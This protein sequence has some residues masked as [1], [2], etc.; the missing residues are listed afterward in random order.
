MVEE[1]SMSPSYLLDQQTVSIDPS[2]TNAHW[3][4]HTVAHFPSRRLFLVQRPPVNA[5]DA[6]AVSMC[7]SASPVGVRMGRAR[8]VRRGQGLA[9]GRPLEIVWN[10]S[11]QVQAP[12]G[13]SERHP[14][15]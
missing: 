5:R 14:G 3:R 6:R 12:S 11:V 4:I 2:R 15:E 1:D 10:V 13:V 8:V 9:V 7:R